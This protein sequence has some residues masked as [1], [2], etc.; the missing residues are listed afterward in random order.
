MKSSALRPGDTMGIIAPSWCGPATFPHRVE[1]GKVA[2]EALG[3]GVVLA[4]HTHGQRGYVSGTREE[5]TDDL[6]IIADMDFGHTSPQF[7]LPI[8]CQAVIDVTQRHF[9]LTEASVVAMSAP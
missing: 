8:G 5:R 9:A 2:L 3:Y 6:H 7:T 1:R 4:P